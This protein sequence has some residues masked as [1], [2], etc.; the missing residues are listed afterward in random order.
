LSEYRRVYQAGG[1]YFF[2]LV[3]HGRKPLPTRP[4]SI[5][6]LRDAFRTVMDRRPFEIE[7]IAVLPDHLHCMWRL[8][9]GDDDFPTRWQLV[10]RYFSIGMVAEV[11]ARN[12]K[13]VWQR[14]YWEHLIRTGPYRRL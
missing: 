11:N 14:R 7:A 10:K 2:T 13:A 6:R 1:C 12:E 3:T 8:P 4:Q 9:D 5:A